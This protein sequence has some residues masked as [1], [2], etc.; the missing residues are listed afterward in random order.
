M[1]DIHSVEHNNE[2][3]DLIVPKQAFLT[4]LRH[5]EHMRTMAIKLKEEFYF[6]TLGHFGHVSGPKSQTVPKIINPVQQFLGP[7]VDQKSRKNERST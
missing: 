2:I 6:K 4:K 7:W 1:I 5:S 3:Y